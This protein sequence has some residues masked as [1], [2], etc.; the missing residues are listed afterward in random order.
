MTSSTV[1]DSDGWLG[2]IGDVSKFWSTS[3]HHVTYT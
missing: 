1:L 3:D 2:I